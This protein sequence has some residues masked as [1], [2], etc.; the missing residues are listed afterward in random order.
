MKKV[1]R[2]AD[3]VV[4]TVKVG[5]AGAKI[6]EDKTVMVSGFGCV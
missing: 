3:M 2:N 6:E 4:K 1:Q 5:V